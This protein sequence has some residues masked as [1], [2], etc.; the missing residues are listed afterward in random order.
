ELVTDTTAGWRFAA[1]GTSYPAGSPPVNPGCDAFDN[2]AVIAVPVGYDIRAGD[3]LSVVLVNVTNPPAG[4]VSDFSVST[5]TDTVGARGAPYTLEAGTTAGVLVSVSP[6]TTGALATYTISDLVASAPMVAGSTTITIEGPAG[7]VFP[8]DAAYYSIEDLTDPSKSATV[9]APVSG[10]GT[11]TVALVVPADIGAADRLVISV[12]DAVNPA[13]AGGDYSV[14]LLGPLIGKPGVSPFPHANLTYPNGAIVD[15]S[16]TDYVFA[17]GHAFGIPS[18]TDLE[19]VEKVDHAEPQSAAG[20]TEPPEGPPRPGTLVFT[21]PVSGNP[22]VY[23][24]GTDGDL[25]G[26]ATPSQLR[27]DGYDPALV[28]TVA[29]LGGVGVGLPAGQLGV[30]GNALATASDGAL[31]TSA[32]SWY[33]LAG[34]RALP[35]PA[36]S[37]G[38]LR[39]QD[40]AMA[41]SGD[42]TPAE[43][44][45]VV[46]GVVVSAGG[47]VYVSYQGELWPFKS[48]SQ[49]AS[50]GY[51]G[52]AAVPVAG[53]GDV[54]VVAAY[55]GS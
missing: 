18:P 2:G 32:G 22:T 29:S 15:F 38:A 42:V 34:G 44:A 21:R 43:A 55:G 8:N 54:P 1:E 28:V 30:S 53:H 11:S 48:L 14:S 10:G 45:N 52:T 13:S 26:F 46:E 12:Q 36:S 31:I 24:A 23:V 5:S 20:G 39:R 6:S 7:T 47:R 41:L 3:T 4:T 25:H 27:S 17:G 51:G 16:G 40:K 50:D 37:L 49:L 33:V 9:A 19:A 35:V